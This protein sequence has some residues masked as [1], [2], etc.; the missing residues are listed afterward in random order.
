M[1]RRTIVFR[2]AQ[3]NGNDLLIKVDE[4]GAAQIKQKLPDAVSILVL[5]SSSGQH[6]KATVSIVNELLLDRRLREASQMLNHHKFDHVVARWLQSSALNAQG[7]PERVH[8]GR[9]IVT[10]RL[11]PRTGKIP[12]RASILTKYSFAKSLETSF[13]RLAMRDR[14]FRKQCGATM[15]YSFIPLVFC[16]CYNLVRSLRLFLLFRPCR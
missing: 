4:R 1:G 15:S 10:I 12:G 14:R 16:G 3:D 7:E 2:K 13:L 9:R 6:E 5:H 11:E 8:C